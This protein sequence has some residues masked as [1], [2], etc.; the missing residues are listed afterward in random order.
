MILLS[1]SILL[2]ENKDE[3][4]GINF[5]KDLKLFKEMKEKF[6]LKLS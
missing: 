5:D 4:F 1:L 6:I 3:S 2:Y